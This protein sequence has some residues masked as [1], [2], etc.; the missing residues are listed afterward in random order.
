MSHFSEPAA[1]QFEKTSSDRLEPIYLG[2]TWIENSISQ[3]RQG[4]RKFSSLR[5]RQVIFPEKD[6]AAAAMHL[7]VGTFTLAEI[8]K[9]ASLS[10]ARL[11]FLRTQIDFMTLVDSLKASFAR[12]FRENLILNEYAPLDYVSIAAEYSTFEELARNQIRVPLF[13][14]MT[15]LAGSISKKEQHRLPIDSYDL[16]SFK[17]LFS[18][19]IFEE[20][21][22]QAL[23]KPSFPELKRIARE[24]VWVRL[25]A[26][27][28]ELD[29]LL[30]PYPM[31]QEVKHEL[32]TR[33]ESLDLH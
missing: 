4:R 18:F 1:M 13:K 19:F 30:S 6:F 20:C 8:A 11:S 14:R 27:Y 9:M 7:Y 5:G 16:R 28:D 26:S 17:K 21:F 25:E 24:I 10:S 12:F 15:Q 23:A 33:L 29:S 2:C 32:R 22:L 31:R 3:Y